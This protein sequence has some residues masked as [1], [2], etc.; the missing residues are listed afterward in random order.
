VQLSAPWMSTASLSVPDVSVSL[1]YFLFLL[2]R[3]SFNVFSGLKRGSLIITTQRQTTAAGEANIFMHESRELW[4]QELH[5]TG[6]INR[7]WRSFQ[8]ICVKTAIL[9]DAK[10]AYSSLLDCCLQIQ[11]RRVPTC[12]H[13]T[14]NDVQSASLGVEAPPQPP[15]PGALIIISVLNTIVMNGA[16]SLTKVWVC[17]LSWVAIFVGCTDWRIFTYVRGCVQKVPTWPTF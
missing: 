9:W 13:V 4:L 17:P 6:N 2:L 8:V 14:T 3:L 5:S 11:G 16:P 1:T 12:G 15:D 7:R 10:Y